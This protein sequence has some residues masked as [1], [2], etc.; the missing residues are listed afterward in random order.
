MK[1]NN[2]KNKLFTEPTNFPT[3]FEKKLYFFHHTN[4]CLEKR[5]FFY[6]TKDL[7]VQAI[8]LDK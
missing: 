2:W 4:D 3:D 6:F 7:T 5:K 8:L 1:K